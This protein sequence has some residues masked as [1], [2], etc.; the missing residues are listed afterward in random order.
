MALPTNCCQYCKKSFTVPE[1]NAHILVCAKTI[2][3]TKAIVEYWNTHGVQAVVTNSNLG[4]QLTEL[5]KGQL[6]LYPV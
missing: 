6:R 3:L 5:W 2:C 1:S 4:P